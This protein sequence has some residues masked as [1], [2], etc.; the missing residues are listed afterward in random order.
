MRPFL[1]FG[2]IL[3]LSQPVFAQSNPNI[4]LIIADDMGVDASACYDVGDTQAKMPNLE[5]LCSEGMV[6]EN[7]YS[8]PVCS[9]TRATIMTGKYGFRTGVGSAIP[10]QGGDGLSA[11]EVSLFDQLSEAN[12]S[13]NL[14]GKWHLAGLKDGLTHPKELG[15]SDYYGLYSG[16]TRSYSSW[17]AVSRGQRQGVD[18]YTT[19]DFT[20]KA[21]DWISVQSSPWF[22]WLAYNA[23]HTPFHLPPSHLHTA[24]DLPEDQASIEA[25]PLPYYNAMLEALDTEIGRLLSELPD[26]ENTLVMFMG[27]NGTPGRTRKTLYGDRGMKGS[28]WEGGVRIPLIAHGPGVLAGRTASLVNTTDI[29]ATILGIASGVSDAPDSISFESAFSGEVSRRKHVYVEHF[30]ANPAN[31]RRRNTA[32]WAIRDHQHKLVRIDGRDP[33]LFDLLTDPFETTDLLTD[34]RIPNAKEI[35]ADLENAKAALE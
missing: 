2:A 4:L 32:G 26:P 5:K 31:M 25:D 14:I 34:E 7:A 21:I 20:N 23:P 33:M 28:F 22:L 9:P 30:T 16:G 1:L 19:T 29:Y 24:G 27:D 35:A 18:V 10:R 17:T 8:A 6:F 13:S 15:V 3:G 11:D 12:Y